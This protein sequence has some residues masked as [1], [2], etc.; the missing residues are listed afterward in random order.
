MS[1]VAQ[2]QPGPPG[3]ND[4]P[5]GQDPDRDQPLWRRMSAFIIALFTLGIGVWLLVYLLSGGRP[6]AAAFTRVGGETRVETALQASSFWREPPRDVVTIPGGESQVTMLE[7]AECAMAHDAPL[8]FT[9][10]DPRRQQMVAATIA[11][12]KS[13]VKVRFNRWNRGDLSIWK[14]AAASDQVRFWGKGDLTECQPDVKPDLS[15]LSTLNIP[16]EPSQL[17]EEVKVQDNLAPLVV[18]AAAKAPGDLPDVAVGL[19]L[20]AHMARGQKVSVEVV[21][22]YLEADP[23]LE[24]QLRGQRQVVEGGIVLGEPRI[25]PEE[26]RALLRQLLTSGD[27]QGFLGEVRNTLGSVGPFI[28]ALVALFGLGKAIET[29]PRQTDVTQLKERL[30]KRAASFKG[31]VRG[32]RDRVVRIVREQREFIVRAIR[33]NRRYLQPALAD[34][35]GLLDEEEKKGPMTIRLI[36]G[37]QV[38]ATI[39][40]SF[41][42]GDSTATIIR[43]EVTKPAGPFSVLVRTENIESIRVPSRDKSS[44]PESQASADEGKPNQASADTSVAA[45]AAVP[46]NGEKVLG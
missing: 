44:T 18:F 1:A 25:M 21:P 26:T 20:A 23:S 2:P 40:E 46:S 43:L 27:Q 6:T 17:P 38:T 42:K 45:A 35:L 16:G 14:R 15:R 36:S 3:V 5:N 7:A 9:S 34:W 30:G 8:L 37:W 22:R 12:W 4:R 29:A 39:P 10:P 33:R 41:R 32:L 28:A 19:A 11:I 31:Q 13:A 24:D